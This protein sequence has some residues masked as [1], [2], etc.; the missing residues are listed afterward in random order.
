M[1]AR[2]ALW[3]ATN[4]AAHL[5]EAHRLLEYLREHAPE[6]DRDTMI[7]NVPLHREIQEAWNDRH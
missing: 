1:D 6:E 3:K 2:F 4:D 5:E 7:E